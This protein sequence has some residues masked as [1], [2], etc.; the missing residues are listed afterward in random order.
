MGLIA[1]R[2]FRV[3]DDR[4]TPKV[5]VINE[6]AAREFFPGDA[7]PLGRLIGPPGN[8][9]EFEVIGIAR[10]A[11]HANLREAAHPMIYQPALQDPKIRDTRLMIRTDGDPQVLVQNARQIIRSVNANVPIMAMTT[12]EE[13]VSRALLRERLIAR[14]A[15]LFA[16]LALVQAAAGLGGVLLYTVARRTREI[17]IR[18]ALG[19]TPR[20]ITG[21]VLGE[22]LG[23]TGAGLLVGLPCA[24][25]AARMA[26]GLLFE[27]TP[28]DPAT[29]IVIS[30]LL[31][32]G[33][34]LATCWPARRASRVD[35]MVALRSE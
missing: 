9:N 25:L 8:R 1:G 23:L 33:A 17:G 32:G 35:P 10:D 13:T 5:V 7:T 18:L 19:A 6:A 11:R 34:C 20:V 2:D 14:V 29:L 3:S 24:L 27:V 31:L 22:S 4:H 21:M 30:T 26:E 15:A 12:L 28:T 16:G